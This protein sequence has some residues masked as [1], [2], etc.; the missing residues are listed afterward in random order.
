MRDSMAPARRPGLAKQTRQEAI[1]THAWVTTGGG[2]LKRCSS[3]DLVVTAQVPTFEYEADYFT[4]PTRGGYDFAADFSMDFDLARFE[5]ELAR[6]ESQAMHGTLLDIGCATGT[7][8][9]AAQRR[10]WTVAGVETAEF[11][12]LEAARRTS[13]LVTASCE[14]LPSGARYDL[15][16][17][18]HV[19]EH[20]HEPIAFLRDTVAPRVG[21]RLLI[22]VPNFGSLASRV[23][24]SKWRDLR[25]EQHVCHYTGTTLSRVVTAAGLRV[26]RV[27]TLWQP[28]WSLRANLELAQL[29]AGGLRGVD[30]RWEPS[31]HIGSHDG[32]SQNGTGGGYVDEKG[33]YRRPTGLRRSAVRMTAL[34][35]RPLVSAL[36]RRG[37]GDRLVV[38]A[39]P[40][41]G[42]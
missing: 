12:R 42:H 41:A 28:L 9:E 7:Y 6:L 5:G 38:E 16:T 13:A 39:E 17:L 30:R 40:G 35:S 8:L 11:A 25:L 37:H 22:E 2:R 27:Y 33:S 24:G 4:D 29:A 14:E 15:V 31:D 10:G 19:L 34:V 21:R 18:H 36:E 20:V 32:V 1:C 23:Y 3:C 26:R